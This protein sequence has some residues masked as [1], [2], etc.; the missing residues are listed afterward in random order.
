MLCRS[1]CSA[2]PSR[3]SA[4]R[5]QPPSRRGPRFRGNHFSRR[6]ARAPRVVD[7]AVGRRARAL[8][9][10]TVD[11]TTRDVQYCPADVGKWPGLADA[12]RNQPGRTKAW[13]AERGLKGGGPENS[14]SFFPQP[15]WRPGQFRGTSCGRRVGWAARRTDGARGVVFH[16][17]DPGKPEVRRWVKTPRSA[18]LAVGGGNRRHL[19]RPTPAEPDPDGGRPGWRWSAPVAGKCATI[20]YRAGGLEQHRRGA[21]YAVPRRP[22]Q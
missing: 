17:T 7:R 16:T 14:A 10:W 22:G 15:G 6:R 20:G 5:A 9:L 12:R 3:Y 11:T 13:I 4:R 2:R 19:K 1:C 21:G 8:V 18:P